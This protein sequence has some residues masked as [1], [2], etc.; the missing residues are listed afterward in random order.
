MVQ[1]QN[2]Q[3]SARIIPGCSNLLPPQFDFFNN[4]HCPHKLNCS[5]S[6]LQTFTQPRMIPQ[7]TLDD[8][9]TVG[10][11]VYS[12]REGSVVFPNVSLHPSDAYSTGYSQLRSVYYYYYY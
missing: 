1:F 10:G 12:G 2:E 3:A 4:F 7:D 11:G 8:G 6:G 5:K 9:I